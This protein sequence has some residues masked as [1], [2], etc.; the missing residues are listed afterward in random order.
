MLLVLCS[1]LLAT[2]GVLLVIRRS[3][4]RHNLAPDSFYRIPGPVS[5]PILG[6]TYLYRRGVYSWDRWVV[7][8]D[9]TIILVNNILGCTGQG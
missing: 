3:V 9:H 2:L 4:A 1:V 8:L 6:T 5:Y 7:R